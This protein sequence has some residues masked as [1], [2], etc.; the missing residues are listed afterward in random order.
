MF[1]VSLSI[2]YCPPTIIANHPR[3]PVFAYRHRYMLQKK[4][5]HRGVD[6]GV[7][8]PGKKFRSGNGLMLIDICLLAYSPWAR[9]L[10][11]S[12]YATVDW[13][14][15]WASTCLP[16][17]CHA[18]PCTCGALVPV[19]IYAQHSTPHTA[20]H[21]GH[22]GLDTNPLMSQHPSTDT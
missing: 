14:G 1:A 12:L 9:L 6:V 15:R 21:N 17:S 11:G 4:Y 5:I 8:W 18:M 19:S 3:K 22:W 13:G 16:C 2:I 7:V 20:S 10:V